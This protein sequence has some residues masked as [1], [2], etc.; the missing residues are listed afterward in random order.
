[1]SVGLLFAFVTSGFSNVDTNIE[2]AAIEIDILIM[3]PDHGTADELLGR[4]Q[5]VEHVPVLKAAQEIW[6]WSRGHL[7]ST[8]DGS[9][10]SIVVGQ[11]DAQANTPMEAIIQNAAMAWRPRYVLILGTALAV[12]YDEPLGVVGLATMICGFDLDRYKKSQD[13][14]RCHRADGGLLT[15]ALSIADEWEAAREKET[16]RVGCSPPRVLKLLAL[17][18]SREVGPSFVD[19]ATKLSEDLHRGL[20][21]E[22]NGIL[23]AQAV[24]RVR[25]EKRRSI[26]MLMIRGIS[27][28]RFPGRRREVEPAAGEQE[29]RRLQEKCA[30]LDAVDF[31]VDLIRN[32]WPVSTVTRNR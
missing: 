4:L 25:Y 26:G 27:E 8:Q 22:R 31:A 6:S 9:V 7:T 15:A 12:A 29:K 14:G 20:M 16:R 19:V 2:G 23:V 3:V 13:A 17:S 21:M 1:M 10:Y 11:L 30:A 24:Q 18:G 5:A 32:R 28:V